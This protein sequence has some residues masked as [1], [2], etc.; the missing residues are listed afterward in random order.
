MLY[1]TRVKIWKGRKEDS[2][3]VKE[4]VSPRS[5][6]NKENQ[7]CHQR[8]EQGNCLGQGKAQDRV[9]EELLCK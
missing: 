8:C 1:P 4:S 5:L 7:E 9:P 2:D 6:K 3:L